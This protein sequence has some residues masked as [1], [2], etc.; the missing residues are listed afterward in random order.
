MTRRRMPRCTT[1]LLSP[2]PFLPA[3]WLG[4][5]M[6]ILLLSCS[7]EKKGNE[8]QHLADRIEHHMRTEVLDKWYPQSVDSEYGGF[9]ST[10]TYDLHP[11]GSQ[12]KMIVTQA[13]H[14]WTN[15]R[16]FELYPDVGQYRDNALHGLKFLYDVMWDKVNGGFYTLVDRQ[17]N[18]R[19]VTVMDAPGKNAYGNAF[20]IYALAA[21]YRA[22]DDTSAF[23]FA[24]RSFLWLDRHARDPVHGGYFN[25]MRE[26]GTVL[27]PGQD[28]SPYSALGTK[29]YNSSIHILEAFTE[30]YHVWPDSLVRERLLEMLHVVRDTL[31]GNK[32]YLTLFVKPDWTAITLRDS[33]RDVILAHYQIDHVTFGHDIETAYLI[34]EASEALGMGH[35]S[36]TY[37]VAKQLV[38]HAL[39]TGWDTTV[40]GFYDAAYY[41]KGEKEIEIIRDTK[42]WWAQAEGLNALLL[43]AD[44]YP[45]DPMDYYGKFL[46]QWSYIDSYLIDHEHGDWYAGGIDKEPDQKTALKGNIWKG[47]YH[48]FRALS[49]CVERL[50]KGK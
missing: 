32:G 47:V 4:Y 44:L 24:R 37:R 8:R 6:A 9:I 35:D 27:Q 1:K 23:N 18:P 17:G 36:T 3:A 5:A 25:A 43:M 30:L 42:N 14:T 40:G 45:D 48:H 10:F 2:R 33:S 26:D 12:D 39:R 49:N 22:L 20:G 41:F 46:K 15:A 34:I 28:A 38:D 11:E 31:I 13:R 19:S 50:R 7:P 16:A 21:C 29:D